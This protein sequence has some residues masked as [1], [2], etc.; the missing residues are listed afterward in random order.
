MS[1]FTKIIKHEQMRSRVKATQLLTLLH[2]F[3]FGTPLKVNGREASIPELTAMQVKTALALLDKVLPN[4]TSVELQMDEDTT[5]FVI[6]A[7]PYTGQEWLDEWRQQQAL[8]GPPNTDL[9]TH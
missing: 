2:A 6:G 1:E 5:R 7:K 3:V 8:S 4:L 9:N